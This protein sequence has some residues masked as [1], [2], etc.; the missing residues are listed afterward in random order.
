MVNVVNKKATELPKDGIPN[1]TTVSQLLCSRVRKA[2]FLTK[3][4]S[5]GSKRILSSYQRNLKRTSGYRSNDRHFDDK[6]LAVIKTYAWSPEEIERQKIYLDNLKGDKEVTFRRN[7][8]RYDMIS[9]GMERMSQPEAPYFGWNK[10]YQKALEMLKN[11]ARQQRLTPLEYTDD[12]SVRQALSKVDAHSGWLYVEE[13]DDSKRSNKYKAHFMKGIHERWN[14]WVDKVLSENVIKEPI[15]IGFRTQASGEYEDDGSQTHK[16]KPKVRV[17]CM[18]HLLNILLG[19]MFCKPYCKALQRSGRYAGIPDDE[20]AKFIDGCRTRFRYFE[21][22]DWT[23]F[24]QKIPSWGLYDSMELIKLSFRSLSSKE[25]KLFD[26][27]RNSVIHKDYILGEGVLHVDHGLDSGESNT[28]FTG[29]DWNWIMCATYM[30]HLGL[31]YG[32]DFVMMCCGDDNIIFSN[33]KL[34]MEDFAGYMLHNFGMNVKTDDKTNGGECRK[35]DPKFLSRY[36]TFNGPWRH[37]N[38]LLSR[39]LFP[40]RFREYGKPIKVFDEDLEDYVDSEELLDP[41]LIFYSFYCSYPNGMQ[42]MCDMERFF[43]DHPG[44]RYRSLDKL[45]GRYLPGYMAYRQVYL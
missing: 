12:A 18:V 3:S 17:I 29:S 43:R 4:L 23:G 37:P 40:E 30:F 24:D 5:A 32:K 9:E 10:N 44:L 21:S 33:V 34:D 16:W 26:L 27:W 42:Q 39:M 13:G 31:E 36:W 20:I 6:L 11:W 38:Q 19:Q 22:I 35:Q 15:L 8:K 45:A 25:E 41:E 7:F 2:D 1:V 14:K 28:N